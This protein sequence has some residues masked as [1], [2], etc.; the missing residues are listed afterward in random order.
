MQ[1]L[2]GREFLDET[3][4]GRGNQALYLL[5]L[6]RMRI[7]ELAPADFGEERRR[8]ETLLTALDF[9]IAFCDKFLSH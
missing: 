4:P 2:P 9:A 7:S 1:E 5:E 6:V 8:W 3:I